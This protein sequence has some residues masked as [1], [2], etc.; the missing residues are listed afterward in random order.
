MRLSVR[1]A[2]AFPASE[3]R[4]THQIRFSMGKGSGPWLEPRSGENH[5]RAPK[6]RVEWRWERDLNPR[7]PLGAYTIS[8]RAPSTT[9]PSHHVQPPCGH[10]TQSSG[11]LVR[12]SNAFGLP[13]ESFVQ[14]SL[15]PT[16]Y[17]KTVNC[18]FRGFVPVI[19]AR[20]PRIGLRGGL[21]RAYN[22]SALIPSSL[23]YEL[24]RC[25]EDQGVYQR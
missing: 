2:S 6:A 10:M 24:C 1:V 16:K 25:F 15:Y 9:R 22:P 23:S 5:E 14:N 13:S 7:D 19:F 11:R 8:S 12:N 17:G 4:C 3:Q 18:M 21:R 20:K